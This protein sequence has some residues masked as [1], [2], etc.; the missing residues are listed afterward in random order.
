MAQENFAVRAGQS[1]KKGQ[2]LGLSGN[3]GNTTGPH[4]HLEV[5]N[6][7]KMSI[8]QAVSQFQATADFPGEMAGGIQVYLVSVM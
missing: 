3:T 6:L 4:C 2:L 1:V 7:G 8:A 5:I